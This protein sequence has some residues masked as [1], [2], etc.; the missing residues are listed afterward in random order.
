MSRPLN[1]PSRVRIAAR[2]LSTQCGL[3]GGRSHCSYTVKIKLE[4]LSHRWALKILFLY[5]SYSSC[6]SNLCTQRELISSNEKCICTSNC[7]LGQP[8]ILFKQF[9][10]RIN[11]GKFIYEYS[12]HVYIIYLY[13]TVYYYWR[14]TIYFVLCCTKKSQCSKLIKS[15]DVSFAQL[16][17]PC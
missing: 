12:I 15:K 6:C 11:L 5:V 1:C 8:A 13:N 17:I 14:S 16:L 4:I 9:F 3:R 10:R 2:V 7:T